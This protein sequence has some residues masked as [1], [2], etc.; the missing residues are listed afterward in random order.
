VSSGSVTPEK[1]HGSG[2]LTIVGAVLLISGVTSGLVGE[3]LHRD[4]VA[5]WRLLAVA[6][7]VLA[8]AGLLCGL[9]LLVLLVAGRSRRRTDLSDAELEWGLDS[10]EDWLNP[11]RSGQR[12][13]GQPAL[14]PLARRDAGYPSPERQPRQPPVDDRRYPSAGGDGWQAGRVA[15][16]RPLPAKHRAPRAPRASGASGAS[17]GQYPS[18]PSP[19]LPYPVSPQHPQAVG[20]QSAGPQ[21]VGPQSV[22]PVGPQSAGPQSVRP[23]GSQQSYSSAPNRARPASAYQPGQPSARSPAGQS[24]VSG[25]SPATPSGHMS[26]EQPLAGEPVVPGA[27]SGPRSAGAPSG[28][29]GTPEGWPGTPEGWPGTTGYPTSP[30]SERRSSGQPLAD[31]AVVPGAPSGP[32][33][34]GAPSGRPDTTGGWPGTAGYPPGTSSERPP[35]RPSTYGDP[36]R[37]PSERPIAGWSVQPG[38]PSGNGLA[39]QRVPPGA[40]PPGQAGLNGATSPGPRYTPAP[41]NDPRPGNDSRPDAR[42][43]SRARPGPEP[44]TRPRSWFESGAAPQGAPAQSPD[45]R[46]GQAQQPGWTVPPGPGTAPR[47]VPAPSA[48]PSSPLPGYATGPPARYG[49][50]LT[51]PPGGGNRGAARSGLGPEPPAPHSREPASRPPSA[52]TAQGA[53]DDTCP[54]PVILPGR[55]GPPATGWEAA[56]ERRPERTRMP[57]PDPEPTPTRELT[58]GSEL[59]PAPAATPR[60]GAQA[61]D[62]G[63]EPLRPPAGGQAAPDAEAGARAARAKLDQLKDLYLT[64]E[65]IGEDALMR[66]FDEVSQRQRDLIRDYFKQPELRPSAVLR[67]PNEDPPQDDQGQ[68]AESA[69]HST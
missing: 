56:P 13:R 15:D 69:T 14:G 37:L 45:I 41:G 58:P 33:S 19:R 9:A 60:P 42:P 7:G 22:R 47:P 46:T 54:L 39:G 40:P 6:G 29:P 48:F 44:A 2:G 11:L 64:A 50:A 36:P 27:P 1:V 17:D 53:L 10:A 65:A 26:F 23:V 67:P 8:A 43:A 30:S 20:P 61:L 57:A 16:G 3:A 35:S 5:T 34:A 62:P 28:R 4:N 55:P 49:A 38:Y 51:P 63:A 25:Y 31:G 12:P 68:Q 66:H 32:R 52:L 18:P 21:S 24:G 59:T